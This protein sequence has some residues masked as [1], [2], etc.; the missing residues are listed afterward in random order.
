MD[1]EDRLGVREVLED[2][3]V[4]QVVQ[5]ADPADQVGHNVDLPVDPVDQCGMQEDKCVDLEVRRAP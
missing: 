4:E 3:N 2:L 5:C 1:L